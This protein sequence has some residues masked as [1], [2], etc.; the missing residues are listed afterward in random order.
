MTQLRDYKNVNVD[1]LQP[2][3]MNSRTH[4]ENQINQIIASIKQFGFTNPCLIDENNNL[5]AG[6]GR[7]AAA[8]RL[9]LTEIPCIVLKD[10]TEIQKKA[11]II[12]DNK[13]ALN[14]GWD[15]DILKSELE[16]I[17]DSDFDLELT[18][19]DLAEI[20]ELFE[21]EY[22]STS[23]DDDSIQEPPQDPVSKYG[24][25]WIMGNH[26]LVCGD[27]TNATDV[28]KLLNGQ[29]PNTMITD[30]PYG[31][32]YEAGWRADAK[33]RKK[34]KREEVS[35]LQNDER[36]DWYD[37]YSLFPGNVAYVWHASTF[38]DVVMDG[39][40]RAGFDVKQQII[41]NKNVHA[42]SRSDYH[43]K[44]EPCWYAVRP[45]GE[46]NWKG[47]R[48]KM[49]VWDVGSIVFDKDKTSHPTQKPVELYIKS[50]E[51][52]TS[53]GEYVYDPFGGSGTLII[54]CQKLN[55]RALVMEL[56]PKFVDVILQ[57]FKDFTGIEPKRD[58]GKTYGSL[59]KEC[60]GSQ[61]NG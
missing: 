53:P 58:D 29:M 26:R 38:T 28:E 16:I 20:D 59:R 24:D 10:L 40:K 44:H 55:R 34:T 43:W 21:I 5:I 47:G 45:E 36:A 19:F 2:Y 3:G 17:R 35:S 1:V 54:A 46:R 32:K 57:R 30:P 41:W 37:T 31:V 49:T 25:I 42:L 48:N 4:S 60:S 13:L 39:L 9:E 18:G 22:E 14:A 12:A 52:H 15:T 27:S 11:L 7:L 61:S 50:L 23:G 8:K 33:G 56:D 51:N 6:H